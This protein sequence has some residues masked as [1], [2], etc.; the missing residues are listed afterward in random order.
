MRAATGNTGRCAKQN[1]G[2]P[3]FEV[4][5]WEKDDLSFSFL[6]SSRIR[7]KETDH[8]PKT[9]QNS[10][11]GFS[12]F[13]AKLTGIS[14]KKTEIGEI[15]NRTVKYQKSPGTDR[16]WM[17]GN[18][19]VLCERM[20]REK[21]DKRKIP[22]FC[23][24]WIGSGAWSLAPRTFTLSS[25]ANAGNKLGTFGIACL[26]RCELSQ[27]GLCYYLSSWDERWWTNCCG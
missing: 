12:I 15:W 7:F 2:I 25:G 10:G 8:F 23:E 21:A 16:L 4:E 26:E 17:K 24:W 22:N 6:L 3:T 9:S 19:H 13:K 1:L 18:G 14:R 5:I 20:W 27:S 11:S